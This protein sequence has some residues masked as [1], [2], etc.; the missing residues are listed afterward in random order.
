MGSVL[1]RAYNG[2][3]ECSKAAAGNCKA[4]KDKMQQQIDQAAKM[5]DGKC[6]RK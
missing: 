6:N 3:T 4:L 5:L 1:L 2:M